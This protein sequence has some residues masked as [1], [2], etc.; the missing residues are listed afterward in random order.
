MKVNSLK[1]ALFFITCLSILIL[2][3]GFL[4]YKNSLIA[5]GAW[6]NAN[7]MLVFLKTDT[8]EAQRN[9]LIKKIESLDKVQSVTLVDRQTAGQAF[10]KSLKEYANSLLTNDEMLD[11]VPET[12]E[13][14]LGTE[15]NL[16][17]RQIAFQT[18]AENL[19]ED[20]AIEELSYSATWLQK[21][22]KIDRFLRSA[23]L[24]VFLVTTL[25]VSYLISLM[26][27]VYI[28]DTK[29]EIEVYNLLGATRWSI[30]KLYLSDLAQFLL[31]SLVVAL[32]L[33]AVFFNYAQT[34][35]TQSGLSKIVADN[36]KF[37]SFREAG[38]LLFILVASI[39]THC[40]FTITSSVNKLNQINND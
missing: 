19:K 39:L 25:L 7:K 12:L 8:L 9:E 40:F 34:A 31:L 36:L 18:L 24:F 2:I 5:I 1:V 22:E 4:V 38:I 27:R 10:Q 3:S 29:S 23:G 32:S 35:L 6:N 11:L 20:A 17:E 33:T 28:D 15:L 16:S 37:L 13:V 30:Y 26:I 14:D 21:F